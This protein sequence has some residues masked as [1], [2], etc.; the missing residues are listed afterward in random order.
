MGILS[1]IDDD[2]LK[3]PVTIAAKT[4]KNQTGLNWE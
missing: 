3:L 4:E 2:A 1:S